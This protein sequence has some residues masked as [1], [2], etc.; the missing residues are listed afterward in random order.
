MHDGRGELGELGRIVLAGAGLIFHLFIAANELR[1]RHPLRASSVDAPSGQPRRSHPI[2][3]RAHHEITQFGA[4]TAQPTNLGAE[5]LWPVWTGA[6]GEVALQQFGD[7]L[8]LLPAGKQGGTLPAVSYLGI[9]HDLK[10]DRV[11]GSS[12]RPVG[13]HTQPQREAITKHGC[14]GARGHKHEHLVRRIPALQY[15]LR[16]ELD[17]SGCFSGAR[18]ADHCC[19]D[20]VC[21]RQNGQL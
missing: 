1:S 15:A 2:L 6:V 20:P 16:D 5:R 3:D 17:Q 10:S 21:D 11:R 18:G 7:D 4:E 12:E 14:P 8:I 9:P 19:G 13:R